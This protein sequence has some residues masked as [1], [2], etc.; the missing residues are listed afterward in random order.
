M[1]CAID[2]GLVVER[3]LLPAIVIRRADSKNRN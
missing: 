1:G 2:V 3:E